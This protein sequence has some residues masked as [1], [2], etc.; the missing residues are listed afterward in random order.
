MITLKSPREIEAIRRSGKITATVL[1]ELMQ[2]ARAGMATRELDRLAERGIRS[3][4]GTPT[5]KGYRGFPASVC[6]SVNDEVVHGIPGAYVL[7]EGDLLSIDLGT[8][9][10]GYVSDSAATLGVGAISPEAQRLL[11]VTQECLMLGIAK[12]QRG[13][14]VGDIGAAVQEHA[15]R[16]GYGV[17]RELVGHGVGQEMHEEPQ[18]PNY[19]RRGTGAAL[20][21]GLVLA[22]E[23][24]VTQGD[25]AIFIRRDG[26]TVV[27]ADGKLAAHFEHTVVVTEHG[28]RILTL[29]EFGE[30]PGSEAFRPDPERNVAAL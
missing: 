29:R 7:R 24:M 1:T 21:P 18:V 19:G 26:W 5:F 16:H 8:T 17:V 22:I 27:T 13:G 14:H 12:M 20:R 30:H 25:P 6:I 9:L 28:P 10:D 15:E 2:A 23:P 11:D 4:G 3:R